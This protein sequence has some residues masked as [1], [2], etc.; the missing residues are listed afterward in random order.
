MP[1]SSQQ[2]L[3]ENEL[4]RIQ[5]GQKQRQINV[6]EE[7]LEG[8]DDVDNKEWQKRIDVQTKEIK[9]LKTKIDE[10]Y[11]LMANQ[12]IEISQLIIDSQSVPEKRNK[13]LTFLKT[14]I[15]FRND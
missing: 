2:L 13:L 11:N 7:L 8:I 10:L 15:P 14:L 5:L 3:Q 12:K 6:M 9:E 4:L 1:V